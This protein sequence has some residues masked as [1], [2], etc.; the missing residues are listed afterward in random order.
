MQI[1]NKIRHIANPESFLHNVL[2]LMTGTVFAQGVLV[3]TLPFLTRIY[4]PEQFGVYGAYSALVGL[5]TIVATAKYDLAIFL[6]K[7]DTDAAVLMF[8]AIGFALISATML[9]F[10]IFLFGDYFLKVLHIT[11]GVWLWVVPL[12]VCSNGIFNTLLSWNNRL[13]RYRQISINRVVQ[14]CLIVSSQFMLGFV[15]ETQ[16]GL[17]YGSVGTYIFTAIWWAGMTWHQDGRQSYSVSWERM[18]NRARA[19]SSVSRYSIGIDFLSQVLYQMPIFFLS[20]LFGATASGYYS[21]TQ[22]I[23]GMPV[24]FVAGAVGDVFRQKASA[25]YTSQN[26]CEDIFVKTFKS[27]SSI[28][29]P[30]ALSLFLFAP[31]L[32]ALAFGESWREAGVYSRILVPIYLLKFIAH[33]LSYV[34]VI[35]GNIKFEYNI[36]VVMLVVLGGGLFLVGTYFHEEFVFLSFY[37][38]VYTMV[39][40]FYLVKSYQFSKGSE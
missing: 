25:I 34:L 11:D 35:T 3:L 15:W 30:L 18:R 29:I 20:H 22:R 5:L 10:I 7:T 16:D 12:S 38:A 40:L 6:E 1:L 31:D 9:A 21:L 39:W 26:S 8:L 24:S 33:P 13:R 23:L 36:L 4:S 37:S 28:S 2:T 19:F 32:F 27:L 17:I 14:S